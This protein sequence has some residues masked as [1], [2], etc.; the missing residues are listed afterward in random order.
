MI[1]S[2]KE[3]NLKIKTKNNIANRD[4]SNRNKKINNIGFLVDASMNITD[5]ALLSFSKLVQLKEKDIQIFK[6]LENKKKIPSLQV[7][8][9]SVKDFN[10]LG[11]LKNKN[12]SQFLDTTFDVIIGIL[13]EE[14]LYL[15]WM[16]S[17][18]KANFKVGFKNA[19]EDLFD[20]IIQ[21][22][23]SHLDVFKTELKKYLQ[24]LNKL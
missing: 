15:N 12:A 9:V 6:F 11:K 13:P 20:L 7:N 1:K 10:W 16:M 21:V 4:I 3:R 2:I 24:V 14:S 5:E 23:P 19:K 18:S 8:E 17:A 22:D